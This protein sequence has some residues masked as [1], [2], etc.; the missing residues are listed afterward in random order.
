MSLSV[1]IRELEL[2]EE[3]S[4]RLGKSVTIFGSARIPPDNPVFRLARQV[5]YELAASGYTVISGGGPGIM[6][7]ASEGAREAGGP[8][9]GF[10]ISLPFEPPDIGLQDRFARH[11]TTLLKNV[12]PLS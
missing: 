5:A 12:P 11:R 6:R 2:V 10:N 3:V 4:S 8:A 9:V 1:I 7:A